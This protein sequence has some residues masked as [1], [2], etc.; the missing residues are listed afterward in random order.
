[1]SPND[2][3]LSNFSSGY[4][5]ELQMSSFYTALCGQ[6]KR[7]LRVVVCSTFTTV[8]CGHGQSS[9]YLRTWK[10]SPLQRQHLGWYGRGHCRG[11]LSATWQDEYSTISWF[12]W[13]CS[14]GI[15]QDVPLA[16]RQSLFQHNGAPGH[17][18]E[19]VR[20][21]LNATCPGRWTERGG[22]IVL[23][24][25]SLIITSTDIFLRHVKEHVYAVPPRTIEDLVARIQ[26]SMSA[27]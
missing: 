11:P 26:R 21:L 17:C 18:R 5:N 14:T 2:R 9:S 13:N 7:A 16:L 3:P 24:L 6:A 20:Q 19:D 1:M 10:L 22:P 27:C 15:L 25:Q 4:N 8:T 23:P 12:S